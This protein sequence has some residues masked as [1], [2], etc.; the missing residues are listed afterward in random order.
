MLDKISFEKE[1]KTQWEDITLLLLWFYQSQLIKSGMLLET[2][3]S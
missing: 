2:K 1:K 3:R